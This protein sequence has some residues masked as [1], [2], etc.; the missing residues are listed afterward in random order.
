MAA[1]FSA[2]RCAMISVSNV[3]FDRAVSAALQQVPDEFRPYL[4][5]VLIEVVDRP[6]PKLMREEDV[7]EDVLGLYVGCPIGEKLLEGGVEAL[8]PDRILIF[9]DN[10]RDMCESFDEL[11]EE[12]RIT[13]LHEIGHHFGM[14]EDQLEEL[15]YD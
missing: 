12:I 5:N 11:V 10:L 9:R 2:A 15:G 6:T 8:L 13:V 3:E 7:P 4:D 14:D 1:K